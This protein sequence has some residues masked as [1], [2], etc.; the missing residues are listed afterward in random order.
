MG[1]GP[2]VTHLLKELL[3][4]TERLAATVKTMAPEDLGRPSLLPGWTRAHVL[5]HIARN[6]DGTRNLLLSVRSGHLVRMYASSATRAADIDA[7]A[8]RP[9]DVIIADALESSRR[10][11]VDA[12]CM[13]AERWAGQIA[14]GSVSAHPALIPAVRPVEMRLREVEFHHVDLGAGYTFADSPEPLLNLLLDDTVTR[15]GGQGVTVN[16][17]ARHGSDDWLVELDDVSYTVGGERPD[18]LSW[19]S[20]RSTGDTLRA[21]QDRLPA[22]PPLG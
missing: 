8:G 3:A 13:P 14:F 12:E 22:L 5:T 18:I 16:G 1:Q 15:L 20:G 2:G 4:A 11:V 10:F 19:F 9:A 21:S 7:G 17:P 6:A